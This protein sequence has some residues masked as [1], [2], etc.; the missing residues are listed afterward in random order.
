MWNWIIK[1]SLSFGRWNKLKNVLDF[2]ESNFK[3]SCIVGSILRLK[4][5][6]NSIFSHLC[7]EEVSQIQKI[8]L[9]WIIYAR[10]L[11]EVI[12]NGLPYWLTGI[13]VFFKSYSDALKRELN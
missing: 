1:L 3:N 7:C 6:I 12:L 10:N 9:E 11:R 2:S 5:C 13:F 4:G 8:G